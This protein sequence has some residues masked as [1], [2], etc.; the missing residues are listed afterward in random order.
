MESRRNCRGVALKPHL[1]PVLTFVLL[2]SASTQSVRSPP[3][4]F[5]AFLTFLKTF[6]LIRNT[7]YKTQEAA[8]H[9][10][11]KTTPV[12]S[13]MEHLLP[14]I[15]NQQDCFAFSLLFV[16]FSPSPLRY[17]SSLV[18]DYFD[19]PLCI[20]QCFGHRLLYYCQKALAAFLQVPKK[21]TNPPSPSI[22]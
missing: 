12:A 11:G 9:I 22:K 15:L 14:Q 19:F 20:C 16:F 7:W 21:P 2:P 4:S 13:L 8:I 3:S 6:L 18:S 10:P 1:S 17:L 5:P